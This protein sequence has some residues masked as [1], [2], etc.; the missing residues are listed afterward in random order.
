M[1]TS[2]IH[3]PQEA[4]RPPVEGVDHVLSWRGGRGEIVT[5]TVAVEEPLEIRLAGCSVAVTMRT[6]GDDLD[7]AAGFL[8]TEGI[9]TGA[10]DIASMSYCPTDDAESAANI[11]NVNPVDPTL[12]DPQRWQRNVY[13]TSSCGI[14]GRASIDAVRQDVPSVHSPLRLEPALLY[15]LA[16]ELTGAQ[17]VFASTGGVHAAALF[18]LDGRL[19]TVR[20]DVGRHNAVDKIIGDALRRGALPLHDHLLL[21]S[22]RA[23]FE[24]VQKALVAGIPAVAAVSAASSL[25]VQLARASGITLVGFLRPAGNDGRFNVYAGMEQ[26]LHGGSTPSSGASE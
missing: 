13:T 8:F 25:A 2:M 10:S 11:V 5:E 14:C 7:L 26:Y 21:V 17:K 4:D 16:R 19:I 20:E 23:S 12:V 6:P 9:I 18:N 1:S 3:L 24:I 15:R 22:S